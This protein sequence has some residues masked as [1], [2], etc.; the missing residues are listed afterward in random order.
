MKLLCLLLKFVESTF[1]VD[2]DCIL[3]V[4]TDVKSL[5]DG[6]RRL[7]GIGSQYFIRLVDGPE[8]MSE[9]PRTRTAAF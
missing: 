8:L 7:F 3:R 4:L 6:L 1:G 9:D 2:I 5:F